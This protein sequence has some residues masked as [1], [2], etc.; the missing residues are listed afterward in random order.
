M[1]RV[2][3]EGRRL[4]LWEETLGSGGGAFSAPSLRDGGQGLGIMSDGRGEAANGR[5]DG[6]AAPGDV[7]DGPSSS[8]GPAQCA[9]ERRAGEAPSLHRR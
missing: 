2:H 7:G 4:S 1:H 9:R 8:A 5:A 6:V 3:E